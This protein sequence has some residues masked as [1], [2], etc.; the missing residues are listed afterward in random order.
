M[1]RIMKYM[2]SRRRKSEKGFTLVEL[3]VVVGI[4]VALA[5][6]IIPNVSRFTGKGNDG[7]LAAEAENVQAAMDT[8]MADIGLITVDPYDAVADLATQ[9]WTG[10][11]AVTGMVITS[12]NTSI[13]LD[14][15]LR[16][17]STKFFYCY[18]A[19]GLITKQFE[20]NLSC[21]S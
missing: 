3:L 21:T 4:I 8:M 9:L 14:G 7:A 18:D 5:A 19:A 2:V 10:L 6:V 17:P 13:T 20:S 16:A 1:R 11:P 12:H 15:Y